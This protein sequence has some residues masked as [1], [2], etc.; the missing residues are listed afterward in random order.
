MGRLFGTDGV[1][2]VANELLTSSLASEI[3]KAGAWVLSGGADKKVKILIGRDTRISGQMLE[4]ALTAGICSV[5]ADVYLLGVAPTPAVAYLTRKY[6][7]DAG[8]V[9]SASHNS[10]E[11]N[12]IKFFDKTGYKLP[13]EVENRIEEYILG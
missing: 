4:A 1:R 10:F 6:G 8:V 11:F 3:G 7:F 9:V 2:G 5:G 13:D 12:G